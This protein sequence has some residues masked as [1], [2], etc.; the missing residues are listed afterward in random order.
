MG[1]GASEQRQVCVARPAANPF[2]ASRSPGCRHEHIENLHARSRRVVPRRRCFR[3]AGAREASAQAARRLEENPPRRRPRHPLVDRDLCRH[4][5]T[6]RSQHG[7]RR[8]DAEGGHRLLGR[9]AD[10]DD[11]L[12]ARSDFRA[13][14]RS[15]EAHLHRRLHLLDHHLRRF[16]LRLLLEGAR[17]SHRGLAL[18]RKRR[19]ASA[20]RAAWRGSAPLPARDDARRLVDGVVEEGAGRNRNRQV[21]PQQPAGRWP[22]PPLAR[23]RCDALLLRRILRERAYRRAEGRREGPRCRLGQGR[24]AGRLDLRCDRHPQ[25]VHA[26]ARSQARPHRH[27]LQRLPHRSAAEAVPGGFRRPGRADDLLG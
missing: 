9:H 13:H 26:R 2:V 11:H 14:Q 1:Q 15:R 20:V 17:E 22:S 25:R 19:D 3:R 4:A 21:L 8:P 27:E 23:S 16:R 12:A 10:A 6:H 18:G 24:H 7:R 5:R